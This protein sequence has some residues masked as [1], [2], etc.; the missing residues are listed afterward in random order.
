MNSNQITEHASSGF[1]TGSNYKSNRK[2]MSEHHFVF[3]CIKV[4]VERFSINI[5][6]S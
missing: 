6:E 5:R 4:Q 1:N 2:P 3:N